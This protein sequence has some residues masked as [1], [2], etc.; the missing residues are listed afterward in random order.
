MLNKGFTRK[1]ASLSLSVNAIVV[2][3]LAI[4]MLGLGLGFIR[5]MFGKVSTQI[6]QAIIAENEPPMPS[7]SIPITLSRESIITNSGNQEVI[8]V[9]SFNPS[10]GTWVDTKPEISCD[11]LAVSGSANSKTI[12]QGSFEIFNMITAIP[13]S[14]PNTYLCK[15]DIMGYSKDMTI[16]IIE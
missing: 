8:K 2:L 4:V 6:E 10:N 9:A 11:G 13:A 7:P 15:M 16:K 3:I 1:K 12:D 5:G 14:P